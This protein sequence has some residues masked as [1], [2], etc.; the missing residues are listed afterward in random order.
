MSI[1]IDTGDFDA[2]KYPIPPKRVEPSET[3]CVH[4]SMPQA[5][6]YFAWYEWCEQ[7]SKTHRQITCPRCGCWAIWWPKKEAIAYNR[8]RQKEIREF[9]KAYLKQF[10]PTGEQRYKQE[11]K[12]ARKRGEIE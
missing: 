10:G 4:T 2:D 1:F 12:E 11:L 6:N 8:A 5:S 7:A 3:E 9:A